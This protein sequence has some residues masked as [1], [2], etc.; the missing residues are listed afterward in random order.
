MGVYLLIETRSSWESPEVDR[1]LEV[2]TA[3]VG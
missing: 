1:F 2:A 3:L